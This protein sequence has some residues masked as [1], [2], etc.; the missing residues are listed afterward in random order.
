MTDEHLLTLAG[1]RNLKK[2]GETWYGLR[3]ED[4]GVS[5]YVG[6]APTVPVTW[7]SCTPF[8]SLYG[9]Q[10]ALAGVKPGGG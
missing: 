6:L 8:P 10:A 3:V 2:F 5:F 7:T 9:A 4:G 1:F